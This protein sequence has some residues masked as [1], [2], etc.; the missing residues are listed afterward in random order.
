[1]EARSND[2][3]QITRLHLAAV[4]VSKCTD[5]YFKSVRYCLQPKEFPRFHYKDAFILSYLVSAL[6]YIERA[7]IISTIIVL[8][9]HVVFC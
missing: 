9:Y 7:K 3:S 2:L 1:M 4:H 5:L 6:S 8:Y